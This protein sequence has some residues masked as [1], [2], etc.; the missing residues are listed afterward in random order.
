MT[1][2]NKA[3]RV[4]NGKWQLA[5]WITTVFLVGTI[6]VLG[7]AVFANDRL[8][9]TEDIRIEQKL[10]YEIDSKFDLITKS[11]SDINTRLARIEGALKIT[12]IVR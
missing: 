11:Y 12:T 1:D 10:A 5:F 2:N 8:R 4:G 3:I 6:F 9:A 7:R